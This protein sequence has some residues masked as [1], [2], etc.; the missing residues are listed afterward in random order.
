MKRLVALLLMAA[1]AAA[2]DNYHM[3]LGDEY[4]LTREGEHVAVLDYLNS[5]A[6]MSPGHDVDLAHDGLAVVVHTDVNANGS[7][8]RI[9]ITAPD[10][11]HVEPP[12]LDVEDGQGGTLILSRIVAGL[13]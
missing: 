12:F 10:G 2:Q 4:Q 11:W 1:P 6:R 13:M 5:D 8:E 9:T 3:Q 7:A